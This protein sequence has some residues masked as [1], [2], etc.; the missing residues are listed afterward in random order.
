MPFYRRERALG[1]REVER[2][3]GWVYFEREVYINFV[4]GIEYGDEA[5]GKI[6][7]AAF[8]EIRRGR[9]IVVNRVPNRR[10]G[11]AV[12]DRSRGGWRAATW[13][14]GEKRLRC[15]GGGD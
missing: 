9:R 8:P 6:L 1:A 14:C 13:F 10:A 12:D 11:E 4:K 2:N 7:E 15:L 5:L 3:F